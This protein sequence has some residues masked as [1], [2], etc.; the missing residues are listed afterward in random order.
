MKIKSD[1]I[2][3]I[4]SIISVVLLCFYYGYV[5]VVSHADREKAVNMIF[6]LPH[7]LLWGITA[8]TILIYPLFSER[9]INILR[10]YAVHL[11]FLFV[12]WTSLS[13]MLISVKYDVLL[14]SDER[15]KVNE[16]LEFE[17]NDFELVTIQRRNKK[18]YNYRVSFTSFPDNTE[19]II[20]INNPVKIGNTTFYFKEWAMAIKN[21][22]YK[23]DN[24]IYNSYENGFFRGNISGYS[25]M[26]MPYDISEDKVVSYR[27]EINNEHEK[28]SGT[29]SGNDE[30]ASPLSISVSE[31]TPS[32]TITLTGSVSPMNFIVFLSGL[33]F[34][35]I[36]F[37]FFF[38]S[39]RRTSDDNN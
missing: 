25:V 20:A 7:T 10:Y 1:R 21:I 32:Y 34:I 38:I 29:F 31:L 8:F 18:S 16:N 11:S 23:I 39:D 27:Y 17:F 30:T 24:M 15:T 13:A 33:L 2:I 37:F 12:I 14:V 9:K 36:L 5:S 6:T 4:T 26:I 28:F 3:F 35:I 19:R 22:N